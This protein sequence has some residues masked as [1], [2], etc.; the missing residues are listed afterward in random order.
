LDIVSIGQANLEAIL[1]KHLQFVGVEV[2]LDHRLV[3]IE[4]DG[5]A[6]RVKITSSASNEDEE[7]TY[8]YLICADGAKGQLL[9][10]LSNQG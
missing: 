1:R 7:E 5:K 9:I 8:Q 10:W 3:D 2:E 4:Q 6:V